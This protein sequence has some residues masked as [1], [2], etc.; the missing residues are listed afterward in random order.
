M[1][2][3]T[4]TAE[5]LKRKEGIEIPCEYGV[6]NCAEEPDP[7]E[8]EDAFKRYARF[9]ALKSRKESKAYH[10]EGTPEPPDFISV[11]TGQCPA[12]KVLQMAR[13]RHVTLTEFL[14]A[15]TILALSECQK[16]SSRRVERPVKVS[17][18]INLR[19]YYPSKT[20]R[21]FSS[22]V[23]PGIEPR[24]GEF[25]FEEILEEVHHFMCMN[26]KEKYLNAIMCKNLSSEMN[27][28]LRAVPLFLKNI[29]LNIAFRKY[30]DNVISATLSNLG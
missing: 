10:F 18:P 15:V 17:V 30:G 4:L 13:E 16:R 3:K 1:F 12:D 9:K 26:V 25:S 22:F 21:N 5:Y 29:A 19:K 6:L 14:V 20:M 7:E 2:L 28:A 8:M 24:Y 23:N 27:P 11:I